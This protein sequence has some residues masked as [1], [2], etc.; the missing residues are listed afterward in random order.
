MTRRR[1]VTTV[2]CCGLA[3]GLSAAIAAEASTFGEP[4]SPG[5][6]RGSTADHQAVS[7]RVTNHGEFVKGFVL[8]AAYTCVT[9]DGN[10]SPGGSVTVTN[11]KK[12]FLVSDFGEIGGALPV[13][14]PGVSGTLKFGVNGEFTAHR[15]VAPTHGDGEVE[16]EFTKDDGDSCQLS[17]G[18]NLKWTARRVHR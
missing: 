6:W 4:P 14:V 11:G 2:V 7:F 13:H 18:G 5:K 1:R 3:V 16:G 10:P 15:D 17:H 8:H 9:S 12:A